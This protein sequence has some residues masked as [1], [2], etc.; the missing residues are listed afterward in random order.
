M[1]ALWG[2]WT[3]FGLNQ[4]LPELWAVA[5][6]W[7]WKDIAPWAGISVSLLWNL[8]NSLLGN[9]QWRKNQNFTEFRS[10][11]TPVDASLGKLRETRRKIQSTDTFGGA[12]KAFNE[13]FQTINKEMVE[14]YISLTT[15]LEACD[16][17]QH[18]PKSDMTQ[19]YD[20]KWDT[21]IAVADSIYSTPVVDEKRKRAGIVASHIHAIVEEVAKEVEAFTSAKIQHGR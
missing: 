10:L 7:P 4:K 18:W 3:S 19:K 5:K 11:K 9:R 15:A 14:N 13:H 12:A 16:V 1:D 17:S 8:C 21:L 20:A 6:A 2:W